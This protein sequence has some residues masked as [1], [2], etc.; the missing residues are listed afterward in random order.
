MATRETAKHDKEVLLQIVVDAVFASGWQCM[1]TD[2]THPFALLLFK[3]DQAS[4]PVRVY[5][6]NCTP[7][8][9]NRPKDEWRIQFTGEWPT[10][11][12]G[13]TTLLLGWHQA[14]GV[15]GGW[16]VGHHSKQKAK[17]PS[18][19]V[20]EETLLR[21]ADR[22]LSTQTKRNGQVVVAFQPQFIVDYAAAA[23][24][25]HGLGLTKAELRPFEDLES[26]D[27][28]VV[29]AIPQK[30]RRLIVARIVQRFRAHDFRRRVLRAYRHHCAFCGV[31]LGLLDAAHL[32]PV[33]ASAST[34][35]TN[36]GIA[37]CKLHHAAFDGNLV[38]FNEAY[39]IEVSTHQSRRLRIAKLS[40]GLADF[41]A[42]L[43]PSILLPAVHRDIPLPAQIRAARA[44][45]GWKP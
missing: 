25:L 17:S 5:I 11:H 15:F 36:N 31:Q 1:V 6:W 22:A 14:F 20:K 43:R 30:A 32:L 4:F 2:P 41:A 18:A 33:A 38:S 3:E 27:D 45:R 10:P 23:E 42:M 21:A 12:A 28:A 34:D 26:G 39:R 8:G 7:G 37:L 16:S 19:Q 13:Q 35:D 44:A 9:E 29:A 24:E 40:G